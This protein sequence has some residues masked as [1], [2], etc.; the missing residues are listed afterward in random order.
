[1]AKLSAACLMLLVALLVAAQLTLPEI[2][3]DRLRERLS[4]HGQVLSVNVSAFP[5]VELLWGQADSVSIA[6]R[7]YGR[8]VGS[9][10]NSAARPVRARPSKPGP[11]AQQRLADLLVST[12]TTDSLTARVGQ[13]RTGRVTLTDVS[14]VK[15]G[16]QLRASGLLTEAAFRAA[17][18]ADFSL[19][20]LTS[21]AGELLFRARVHVLGQSLSLTARLIARHGALVVEPDVVGFFPGFAALTVFRD[22]RVTVQTVH[23]EQVGGGWELSA[24]GRL[25]VG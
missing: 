23:A 16:S 14:F 2:A 17:Q 21:S 25:N 18:P 20:P 5:A 24:T 4:A 6:M 8:S 11:T 12:S 3:A 15:H 9:G 19:Q 10:D 7:S 22:P 13:L 1:M